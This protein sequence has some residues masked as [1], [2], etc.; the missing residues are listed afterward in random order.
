MAKASAMLP[1]PARG[2]DL[3]KAQYNVTN[4]FIESELDD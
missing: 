4:N 3:D 2:F 1:F